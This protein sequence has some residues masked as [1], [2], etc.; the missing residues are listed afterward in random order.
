M[1]HHIDDSIVVLVGVSYWP[2]ARDQ[3][4]P[5][6]GQMRD[7]PKTLMTTTLVRSDVISLRASV[8]PTDRL[9]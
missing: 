3:G 5:G 9:P 8:E 2:H 6:I 7:A 4:G 1:R